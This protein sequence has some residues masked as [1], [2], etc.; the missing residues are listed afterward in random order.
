MFLATNSDFASEQNSVLPDGVLTGSLL[1]FCMNKQ[2]CF[3]IYL[4]FPYI[5]LCGAAFVNYFFIFF[6]V[7]VKAI[8]YRLK[9]DYEKAKEAFE[10]A[11]KGQEMISSY[12]VL[13]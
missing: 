6:C 10:K 8:A 12:P 2:V 11:S 7:C 1:L 4:L 9:K 3:F 13:I 5:S